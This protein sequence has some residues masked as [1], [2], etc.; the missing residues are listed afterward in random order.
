MIGDV[1]WD[2]P[3]PTS[4]GSLPLGNGDLA[5]NVWIEPS[6]DLVFYVAKNDAWDHVGRLIKLG[7]LRVSLTPGLLAGG[8]FEQKLSL[9]DASFIATNGITT[10][11]VWIDAHWP[12]VVVE[13]SSAEPVAVR[14]SLDPW[15]TAPR[16]LTAKEYH[17]VC[18]LEG[19]SLP[20]VFQPDQVVAGLP[21]AVVWYQRNE[22]SIWPLTLDQQGL[23]AFK[24][25]SADPLLHW[26][27]GA[28]LTAAGFRK[29]GDAALVSPGKI[30]SATFFIDAHAARAAAPADWIAQIRDKAAAAAKLTL[31]DLWRDHRQWWTDFW[32]RSH[33]RLVSRAP[34]WGVAAQVA[35]QS[36]WQRY[37]VA[38]CSRGLYPMKFNGGLFTADWGMKEYN[39]DA[40]FRQW[41]G[42]YWFQNTRLIYWSAL[43]NGDYELLRPFFRMYR[44]MLPLAEA[45]TQAYFGHH[46]AFFPETLYFWGTYLPS[47]YGWDRTGKADGEVE[48]RYIRRYWQGGLEL[49]ALMLE[50]YAHT[51][52]QALL[53][54]DLLPVARAVLTFQAEHY[55]RDAA[56]KLRYEPAQSLETWWETVN[57][58]PEIAALHWLLPQLLTLPAVHLT[59]ADRRAWRDLADRLPAVPQGMRDGRKILLPAEKHEPVPSNS[60]NPELYAVF[61]YRLYGLGR[62]DLDVAQWTF[63]RRM[64]PDT[65]GWR[66]DAVQA[67]LL[68]L[69][70]TAMFY[71]AKN[72]TDGIYTAHARFKGFW[73]P[74]FDWV[75]DFDHGSVAQLGLQTML[76]QTVGEKI[77]LFPA[78]P[79]DRWNVDFKLHLPG[80]TVIEGELKDGKLL[81]LQVTPEARRADLVVLLDR[82][83]APLVFA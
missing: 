14:A 57:P 35:E 51:R 47:N 74:N 1:I 46:G 39:F 43:A 22:T 61:P 69:T 45:R 83:K 80:Q 30:T 10:L 24:A 4:A 55:P 28:S 63:T 25:Q 79:V 17:T 26:T 8:K 76:V 37:M 65:G 21:D 56:G 64:I 59:E 27:F 44:D 54:N 2:S 33:I 29:E 12:R 19:G 40:D 49:V 6:G 9:A 20:V 13:V 78:W 72:Y 5:A 62:P 3:S 15:R 38:C 52:D 11:R 41:G 60:E 31:S 53:E 23:G 71:V 42:G 81:R 32:A 73:G 58:M 75:P 48:N 7:R 36:A 70:E 34:D 67:A 77:L 82:A 16:E 18:G 68:G 50:T 66:Q